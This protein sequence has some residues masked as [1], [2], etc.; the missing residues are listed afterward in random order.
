[1]NNC[2]DE[3]VS[4]E[5]CKPYINN[6]MNKTF[7]DVDRTMCTPCPANEQSMWSEWGEWSLVQGE[8]C[9][10]GVRKEERRRACAAGKDGT[11]NC[12][13][14]DTET[15]EYKLNPCPDNNGG[16]NSEYNYGAESESGMEDG[17][18]PG[19][20]EG[21]NDDG[22]MV[23]NDNDGAEG[24]YPGAADDR[25]GEGGADADNGMDPGGEGEEDTYPGADGEGVGEGD[26]GG[27]GGDA[28]YPGGGQEV[29]GGDGAA[30][31]DGEDGTYP[32]TGEPEDSNMGE[33]TPEV[34]TDYADEYDTTESEDYN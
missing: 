6:I 13:G 24:E 25:N 5:K 34:G 17:Q 19:T 32:G 21:A 12:E 16:G 4:K 3:E 22:G 29:V 1:M 15:K 23:V 8:K 14:K 7:T 31:E 10:S 20:D 11:K 9:G 26:A 33:Y 28:T 2:K 30:G 18:N 27:D